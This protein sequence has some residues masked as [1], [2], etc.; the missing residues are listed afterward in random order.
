MHAELLRGLSVDTE[1]GAI[2]L[3]RSLGELGN[4]SSNGPPR[5]RTGRGNHGACTNVSRSVLSGT[6]L[7]ERC[8]NGRNFSGPT[9]RAAIRANAETRNAGGGWG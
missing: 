9:V 2:G 5:G 6:S 1:I 3:V 7:S 8:P 4:C